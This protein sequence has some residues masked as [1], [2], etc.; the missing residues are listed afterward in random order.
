M[1]MRMTTTKSITTM[2]KR[3]TRAVAGAVIV[4]A[5]ILPVRVEAQGAG[6]DAGDEALIRAALTHYLVGHETGQG[7]HF[8]AAFHPDAELLWV[9]DGALSTR[10]A[11]SYI[12]GARGTPAAD[13]DRRSRRIAWI[14]IAGDV[15]TARV[16]LD[17][18]GV[19]FVDYMTLARTADG[20]RI[21]SKAFQ[22]DRSGALRAE[23]RSAGAPGGADDGAEGSA[24]AAAA[25][26]AERSAAFS[27]AY[28]AG[29]TVA[30]R[31]LYTA[32]AL[33]LP[34]GGFVQGADRVARYFAPGPRRENLAHAMD[35]EH[36]DVRGSTAVDVGSWSNSWR[37][38]DG[39]VAEASDRYLIVWRREDDGRWRIAYDMWH[40]PSS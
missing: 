31:E 26:I 27:R 18:P 10:S 23:A 34:P 17:Y 33:L 11:E 8:A 38:D 40:R 32:D 15:A 30:I 36:L 5:T 19:F 6:E 21:V 20:W 14:D 2:T 1:T 3:V 39:P 22:S 4:A 37:V 35:S 9:A 28:L 7:E 24:S 13:E 29:D 12:A 25:A 16:E